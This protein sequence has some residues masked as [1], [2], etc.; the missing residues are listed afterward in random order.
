MVLITCVTVWS[1]QETI[2]GGAFVKDAAG[3][4]FCGWLFAV[5]PLF[6]EIQSLRLFQQTALHF[7]TAICPYLILA[8]IIGWVPANLQSLLLSASVFLLIYVFIWTG[9]YLYFKREAQRINQKLN[10]L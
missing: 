4:V 9:F 8:T 10:Q 5:T 2:Q 7:F 3:Y 6:F 1:G